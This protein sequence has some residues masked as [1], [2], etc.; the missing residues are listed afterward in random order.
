MITRAFCSALHVIKIQWFEWLPCM[1]VY[2]CIVCVCV[3]VSV[4]HC[5]FYVFV[6]LYWLHI[7]L[8]LSVNKI[9]AKCIMDHY[10]LLYLHQNGS[11]CIYLCFMH[12]ISHWPY[13]DLSHH[14]LHATVCR[15]FLAG[16]R[17][18][19]FSGWVGWG[20]LPWQPAGQHLKRAK[21]EQ[22]SG[23][24]VRQV[25]YHDNPHDSMHFE[26]WLDMVIGP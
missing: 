15:K 3:H 7:R 20:W 22:R 4:M 24:Q 12:K 8:C 6:Q 10:F 16:I 1:Y 19:S 23:R 25:L 5:F 2:V 26:N 18:H 13:L 14:A 9:L 21:C 11:I 17:S